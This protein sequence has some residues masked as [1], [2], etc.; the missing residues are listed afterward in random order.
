MQLVICPYCGRQAKYVDSA[1][2][3]HGKSYGMIYL[4]RYCNAWVGVHKGTDKPL[5]RLADG[6]LRKAKQKAH[7][8]FDPMWMSGAMTRRQAY[9]WLAEWLEIEIHKCHIG[10]FDIETCESVFRLCYEKRYQRKDGQLF[11]FV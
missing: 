6:D 4:C 8:A 10:M 7:K 5:G 9:E 2:V 1:E 3:Y 11:S